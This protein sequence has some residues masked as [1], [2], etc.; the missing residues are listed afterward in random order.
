[1]SYYH[2]YGYTNQAQT[3][4]VGPI[5]NLLIGTIPASPIAKS[6]RME[7]GSWLF[8]SKHMQAKQYQYLHTHIQHEK[9]ILTIQ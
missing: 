6:I 8:P 7:S 1:M 3:E 4:Q 9:W 5:F 2:A